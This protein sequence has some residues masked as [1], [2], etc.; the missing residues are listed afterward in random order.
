MVRDD[1]FQHHLILP[2]EVE[3]DLS[4]ESNKIVNNID[5]RLEF[6]LNDIN[7]IIVNNESEID[8]IKD[9]LQNNIDIK[10]DTGD[11][12]INPKKHI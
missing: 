1:R 12:L 8:T 7:Y 5:V 9:V 10:I 6:D 2:G 11:N 4:N 3:R